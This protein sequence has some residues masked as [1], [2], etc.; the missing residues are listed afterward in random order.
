[1]WGKPT[2][3]LLFSPAVGL[4]QD[5][6]QES[7]SESLSAGANEG[8]LVA[9]VDT[10]VSASEVTEATDFDTAMAVLS[11]YLIFEADGQRYFDAAE[12][13]LTMLL[14]TS[15]PPAMSSTDSACSCDRELLQGIR[16]NRGNFHGFGENAMALAIATWF[17]SAP[18]NPLA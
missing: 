18:C 13:R 11:D 14:T 3:G 17:N 8:N 6:G 5:F 15:L 10:G 12:L 1:M 4:A 2:L 16:D 9:V 7:A